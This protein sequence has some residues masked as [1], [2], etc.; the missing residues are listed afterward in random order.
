MRP[1]SLLPLFLLLTGCV[2]G[3]SVAPVSGRVTLTGTPLADAAVLFQPVSSDGNENPGPGSTGVTDADGRYTLTLVGKDIKGA[4][5][6]KHKVRITMFRKDDS[7]EDRPKRVKQF[8]L[9]ARYSD[10]HTTL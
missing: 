2:G 8:Q 7:S 6:G 3:Y 9:P 10:K 1:L 4:V 5:V